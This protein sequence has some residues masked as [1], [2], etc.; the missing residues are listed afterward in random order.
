MKKIL[1]KGL[2]FRATTRGNPAHFKNSDWLYET[3]AWSIS[4]D[5]SHSQ[6]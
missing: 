1:K 3:A 4:I 5:Y 2:F 6:Q